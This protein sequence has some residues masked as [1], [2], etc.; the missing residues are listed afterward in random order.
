VLWEV[1]WTIRVSELK[2]KLFLNVSILRQSCKKQIDFVSDDDLG[3]VCS[4]YALFTREEIDPF[5][6]VLHLPEGLVTCYLDH[7]VAS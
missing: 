4:L 3:V 1:S 6:C 2:N 5:T 7:K